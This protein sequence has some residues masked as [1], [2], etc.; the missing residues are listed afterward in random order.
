[1]NILG[2]N[3]TK[4][5]ANRNSKILQN[6]MMNT[7]I[8]FTDVVKEEIEMLKENDA[9]KISFKFSVD[10]ADAKDKEKKNP[11]IEGKIEFEGII[12]LSAEKEEAKEI[13]KLWKKKQIPEGIRIPLFNVILRKCSPKAL[14]MEDQIGLPLH[15][16]F[17]QIQPSNKE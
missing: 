7:N 17:P 16:P 6:P 4:I 5:S 2:F 3:L 11:E 10:Y 14:D 12:I 15:L 8:E 13:F 9:V 1:M